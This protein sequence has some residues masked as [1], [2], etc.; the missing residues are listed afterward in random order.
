MTFRE[1]HR[2]HDHVFFIASNSETG[3][4]FRNVKSRQAFMKRVF[5]LEIIGNHSRYKIQ[6][7]STTTGKSRPGSTRH[8]YN[9]IFATKD[10]Y[11]WT[12]NALALS[13]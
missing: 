7:H 2:F 9:T 12:I 8:K 6:S 10:L 11:E 13:K 1:A 5:N 3:N 4:L